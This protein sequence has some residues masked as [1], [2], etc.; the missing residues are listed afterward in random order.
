MLQSIGI[1]FLINVNISSIFAT[2]TTF[3]NTTGALFMTSVASAED[4]KE[5]IKVD[6]SAYF[7]VESES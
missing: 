2:V 6:G 1:C 4:Y 5:P 3:K 7:S